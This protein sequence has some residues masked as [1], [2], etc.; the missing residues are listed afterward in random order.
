M[1]KIQNYLMKD[2]DPNDTPSVD[3]TPAVSESIP[4][5]VGP[6]GETMTPTVLFGSSFQADLENWLLQIKEIQ[7]K[8]ILEG[9]EF[10][11]ISPVATLTEPVILWVRAPPL[12]KPI[13]RERTITLVVP[14]LPLQ[15]L[16]L[17]YVMETQVDPSR[18]KIWRH[19]ENFLGLNIQL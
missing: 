12:A 11:P 10:T 2:G 3:E 19:P 15:F 5:Q 18:S 1:E 14:G 4:P 13:Y 17:Q 16:W 6:S 8:G 7:L 9:P